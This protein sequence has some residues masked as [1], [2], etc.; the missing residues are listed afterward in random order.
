VTTTN[1]KNAYS[2][3]P[4]EI[5]RQITRMHYY[6]KKLTRL[7]YWLEYKKET[8]LFYK[9]RENLID[10]LDIKQYF[11]NYYS[12][13]LFPFMVYGLYKFILKKDGLLF[14]LS[15]FSFLLLA[16][17]GVHGKYGPFLIFPY[18]NLWSCIGIE[19]FLKVLS[20]FI[21]PLVLRFFNTRG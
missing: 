3:T 16:T 8:L 20:R 9:F 10:T 13:I 6:P 11:P 19:I 5:D 1:I 17:I 21:K 4:S 7:G 18:L 15:A 12:Y 14:F 2:Y